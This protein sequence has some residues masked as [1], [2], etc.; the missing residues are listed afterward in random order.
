MPLTST[1]TRKDVKIRSPCN[2]HR[3]M[4]LA[5]NLSCKECMYS[6]KSLFSRSI[7]LVLLLLKLRCNVLCLLQQFTSSCRLLQNLQVEHVKEWNEYEACTESCYQKI[8][9]RALFLEQCARKGILLSGIISW[10]K[11]IGITYSRKDV[12]LDLAAKCAVPAQCLLI[13]QKKRPHPV[14]LPTFHLPH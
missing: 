5:S 9:S 2:T 7:Q 10:Y 14:L 3:T 12:V 4:S 1:D 11:R 6:I 8:V 13:W